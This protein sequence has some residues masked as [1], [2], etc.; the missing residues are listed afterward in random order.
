MQMAE[1]AAIVTP[2]SPASA[3]ARTGVPLSQPTSQAALKPVQ[4]TASAPVA[5]NRAAA[6]TASKLNP[7]LIWGVAAFAVIALL[8]LGVRNYSN[9]RAASEA[10]KLDARK[11]PVHVTLDSPD[12]VKVVDDR[13]GSEVTDDLEFGL[14]AGDYTLTASRAGFAPITQKFTIQ[15]AS[16]PEESLALHWTALPT[17]L[18]IALAGSVGTVKINN[19]AQT[20]DGSELKKDLPDGQYSI[21]WASSD[22]DYMDIELEVKQTSATIMK[23]TFQGSP[24]VSGMAAALSQKTVSFQSINLNGGITKTIDGQQEKLGSDGSFDVARGQKIGFSAPRFNNRPLGEMY[25]EPGGQP[26][27]YVYLVPPSGSRS[28][29]GNQKQNVSQP[30]EKPKE[31]TAS[32]AQPQPQAP[33]ESQDKKQ[34]D[35]DKAAEEYR[36]KNGLPPLSN[37][38]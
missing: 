28:G 14:G 33:S 27:V 8:I 4:P 22:K 23:P 2:R 7:K 16:E 15:P 18:R 1:T 5:Q 35:D 17:Q 32:Q 19:V 20:L 26:V 11:V 30:S 6:K 29:G 25:A 38:K 9:S 10:K 37:K 3:P 34:T 24:G 13:T 36:R 31:S 12:S 21:Q